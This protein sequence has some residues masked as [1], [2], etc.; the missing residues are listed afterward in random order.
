MFRETKPII[1]TT[2]GSKKSVKD[3]TKSTK[4]DN[5]NKVVFKSEIDG[6]VITEKCK[7]WV[8][9]LTGEQWNYLLNIVGKKNMY[10]SAYAGKGIMQ[11]DIIF[12]YMKPEK[13][14]KH[15][16]F[17]ALGQVKT[18]MEK[19]IKGITVFNDKNMNRYITELNTIGMFS[20]PCKIGEFNDL[21][22]E[23]TNSKIKGSRR[24]AMVYLKGECAFTELP[25]KKLGVSL[26]RKL[27]ELTHNAV[28]E[29]EFQQN[30]ADNN[31]DTDSNRYSDEVTDDSVVETDNSDSDDQDSDKNTKN[32]RSA[33][34]GLNHKSIK[35]KTKDH[36]KTKTTATIKSKKNISSSDESD[37]SDNSDYDSNNDSDDQ[38]K[39]R[40]K[41]NT[42]LNTKSSQDRKNKVVS[43]KILQK[44][45]CQITKKIPQEDESLRPRLKGK[46][47]STQT[48]DLSSNK[49]SES[50][51]SKVDAKKGQK[52]IVRQEKFSD[53]DSE[54]EYSDDPDDFDDE[55]ESDE[56]SVNNG[57]EGNIPIMFII[58]PK[59]RKNLENLKE[60]LNKVKAVMDHYKY[61]N[62]CDITN[63]NSREMYMTLNRIDQLNI[64]FVVNG[65]DNALNAYLSMEQFPKYV[66]SEY[67]KMYHMLNSEDYQGDILIE[68]TSKIEP[69]VEVK[70]DQPVRVK[71]KNDSNKV[72][73]DKQK[74][75]VI[76]S[77]KVEK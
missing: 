40:P 20:D 77:K 37:E 35:P 36:Q 3:D 21:I 43:R 62:N 54:T 32:N 1:K 9:V 12:F 14:G 60:S 70:E 39:R 24:F 13:A 25:F 26:V 63:N 69:I 46:S 7:F 51:K 17:V 38:M 67:I 75:R 23:T 49:S 4:I 33:K 11:N 28:E 68:Y 19:N 56:E 42:K 15:A 76:K 65:Y 66:G 16:G 27:L 52:P 61:C 34:S 8:Y 59:L 55:D 73:D 31:P 58:C 64:K 5:Q 10:V 22:I 41:L 57:I 44:S 53:N 2:S 71:G 50:N 48:I 47:K 72:N 6:I 74:K 45:S 29:E 18:N 30:S